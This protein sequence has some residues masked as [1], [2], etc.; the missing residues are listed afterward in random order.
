MKIYFIC[1][2]QVLSYHLILVPWSVTHFPSGEAIS[3]SQK[4]IHRIRISQ[5]EP[6]RSNL[7][8][9]FFKF[10]GKNENL[11]L[12]KRVHAWKYFVETW[13]CWFLFDYFFVK[14][15]NRIRYLLI[16]II[17]SGSCELAVRMNLLSVR[18]Q[19]N[20]QTKNYGPEQK[21]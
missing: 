20:S 8:P 18:I 6:D 16:R 12:K 15:E 7:N 3:K 17:G 10:I 14:D 9:F 21:I 4:K 13:I 1:G 19:Q 2:Q 11:F 5:K